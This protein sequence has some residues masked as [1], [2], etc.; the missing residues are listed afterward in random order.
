MGKKNKLKYKKKSKAQYKNTKTNLQIALENVD[1]AFREGKKLGIGIKKDNLRNSTY[2]AYKDSMVTMLNDLAKIHGQDFKRLLP[3]FMNGETWDKY[4]EDLTDRYRDGTLSAGQIQ[5]RV[6][7]LELFRKI[8]N[9]TTVCG[10]DTKIRVGNKIERLD[11][12]KFHGVVRSKDEITAM[13]ATNKEMD[14]VQSHIN[15][16]TKSGKTALLVNQV[17]TE[18]GGRIKS[19]FKLEVQD[20]NFRNKTITFRN[21]KN[22]FTR[23]VPM[24]VAAEK[25]LSDACFGKKPGSPVFTITDADGNDMKIEKAVKTVQRYTNNAAKKSGINRDDRRFTTHSNRK[26]YAQGLYNSTRYMTKQ[27]LKKEIGKYVRNQGSNQA[28]I[29]ERMKKEL[30]RINYYRKKN[31]KEVQGFSHEHLRRMLVSLHLGHSRIDIVGRS[32]IVPDK[33]RKVA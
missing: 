2:E 16:K 14:L 18:C 21:D 23:T 8:V 28:I 13:K 9:T 20:I 30:D 19:I 17:Q 26:G 11:Y 33:I 32:Y 27:Q 3:A 15:T 25:I 10:E 6:H 12:L 29:V 4:F 5:R 1:A 31:G 24:T 22:N 7:G